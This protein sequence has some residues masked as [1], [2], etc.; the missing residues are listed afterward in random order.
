VCIRFGFGGNGASR[1]VGEADLGQFLKDWPCGRDGMVGR[2][3]LD[4]VDPRR[5]VSNC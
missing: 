3:L 5:N 1:H 4:F 2:R